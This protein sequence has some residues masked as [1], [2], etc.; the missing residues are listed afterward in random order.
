MS[1]SPNM[2]SAR[3]VSLASLLSALLL[4]WILARSFVI[5][6]DSGVNLFA[7]G[8]IVDI[9]NKMRNGY[10]RKGLTNVWEAECL[11]CWSAVLDKFAYCEQSPVGKVQGSTKRGFKSLSIFI[12]YCWCI[13]EVLLK[14][15]QYTAGLLSIYCWYLLLMCNQYIADVSIYRWCI[16]KLL[17]Y[18]R[19]LTYYRSIDNVS[20][21]Y[22]YLPSL[23]YLCCR[24]LF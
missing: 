16:D 17:M 3:N 12:M 22:R 1:F 6:R 23:Y 13:I 2:V 24:P 7:G 20:M 19:L 10:R 8:I 4:P 9:I 18:Y 11:S 5:D 14:S 15:Y 21:V